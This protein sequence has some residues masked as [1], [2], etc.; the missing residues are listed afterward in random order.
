MNRREKIVFM[1]NLDGKGLEIGPSI[2]PIVPKRE[3]YNV[4]TIDH[5]D[6]ES[7]KKKYLVLGHDVDNIEEVDYIWNGQLYTELT[8]KKNYYDYII[9]SHVIEHTCDLIGFLC[10]CSNI[11]NKNGILSLAVPDKRFCYDY[12]RPTT[13]ISKVI[14]SH[15]KPY[16]V[17]TPGTLYEYVSNACAFNGKISWSYRDI[18]VDIN[19]YH[20]LEEAIKKYKKSLKQDEYIDVHNWV[21]TK[22]SFELMI[23]DLNCLGLLDLQ[24]IKSFETVEDEFFVSLGKRKDAFIPNDAE[25]FTLAVNT[26]NEFG[27]SNQD[28]DL[29]KQV[30]ALKQEINRLEREISNIYKTNTWKTGKKIQKIYRAFIPEKK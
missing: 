29:V 27:I 9:A 8:G 4:E 22:S 17:H 28:Q 16:T 19:P 2:R 26:L 3:G 14:D 10:D 25:R 24:I 23:Y 21:F 5:A 12:L 20:N 1:C 11:L 18:P 7:L 13:S 6:K 30:N 15:L